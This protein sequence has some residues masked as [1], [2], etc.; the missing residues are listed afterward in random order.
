[1]EIQ[2]VFKNQ[3]WQKQG[4]ISTVQERILALFLDVILH[5]PFLYLILAASQRKLNILAQTGREGYQYAF[6]MSQNVILIVL[7]S[8]IFQILYLKF[9]ATTPGKRALK[10]KV[11][12]LNGD[13]LTD[14]LTD[15]L[16]WGQCIVRSVLWWLEVATLGFGFL[17]ILSQTSRRPVH[18][19]AA[20]T[21]VISVKQRTVPLPSESELVFVRA[22]LFTFFFA[23]LGWLAGFVSDQNFKIKNGL[24]GNSKLLE[25][26]GLLCSKISELAGQAARDVDSTADRMDFATSLYMLGQIDNSC[27]EREVDYSFTRLNSEMNSADLSYFGRALLAVSKSEEQ[28]EYIEKICT[29]KNSLLCVALQ[30]YLP[31]FSGKQSSEQSGKQ[32]SEI[33]KTISSQNFNEKSLTFKVSLLKYYNRTSQNDKALRVLSEL[34]NEGLKSTGLIKEHIL[35]LTHMSNDLAVQTAL[36]AAKSVVLKEDYFRIT[37]E[38]CLAHLNSSCENPN[39]SCEEFKSLISEWSHLLSEK[40]VARAFIKQ[41]YC[42]Q[43]V[44]VNSD[45]W[46][47]IEDEENQ[48]LLA[49]L[50]QMKSKNEKIIGLSKLRKFV[51]DKSISSEMRTDAFQILM[52]E[53]SRRP[54]S[55]EASGFNVK[56]GGI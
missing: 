25:D 34:Q 52:H 10:L 12:S 43:Q 54:A 27:F 17:E 49:L 5:L 6:L 8:M 35:A 51:A 13:G 1:M 11:I 36:M 55:Q 29:L 22:F 26:Q 44:L 37:A 48:R 46:S 53:T 40:G 14:R 16:T 3:K 50:I 2:S 23:I 7:S 38:S 15:R 39:K 30:L 31:E 28:K 24:I 45:Y 19:R 56:G 41:S 9:Q 47:Q 4:S 20:E 33:E 42:S 21:M 32:S 18:D